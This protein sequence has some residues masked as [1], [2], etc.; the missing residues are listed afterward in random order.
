M[1][2]ILE[3]VYFCE[4]QEQS[5]FR[6][7]HINEIAIYVDGSN[8]AQFW[9]F[10]FTNVQQNLTLHVKN[11]LRPEIGCHLLNVLICPNLY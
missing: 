6:Y 8:Y 3:T 9:F 1:V 11:F 5:Y 2:I 10:L 7:I 4:N